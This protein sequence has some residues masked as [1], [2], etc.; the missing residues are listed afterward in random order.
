MQPQNPVT[1]VCFVRSSPTDTAPRETTEHS[2]DG[3]VIGA[4]RFET[5]CAP[6][7]QTAFDRAVATLHSFEF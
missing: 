5:S 1:D 3:D 2:D 7:V 6:E 4:V